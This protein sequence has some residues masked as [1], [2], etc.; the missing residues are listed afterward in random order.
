MN[1]PSIGVMVASVNGTHD[2]VSVVV[3]PR[4]IDEYPKHV[5]SF[6]ESVAFSSMSESYCPDLGITE[7]MFPRN[8]QA[9][10]SFK[11]IDS[12]WLKSYE[13]GKWFLPGVSDD[14]ASEKQLYHY[15]LFGIDNIVQ[16]VT[17]SAPKIETITESKTINI[18]YKV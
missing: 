18:K 7:D 12:P 2:C 17:A 3:A 11:W 9:I 15:I 16:I 8:Y 13:T 6:G 1:D 10:C 14:G 4:G 5:I